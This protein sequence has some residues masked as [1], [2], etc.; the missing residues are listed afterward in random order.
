MKNLRFHAKRLA[1]SLDRNQ[2]IQISTKN[3][4]FIEFFVVRSWF[5]RNQTTQKVNSLLY[6]PKGVLDWQLRRHG[7]VAGEEGCTNRGSDFDD[8]AGVHLKTPPRFADFL[9]HILDHV[10]SNRKPIVGIGSRHPHPHDKRW[11]GVIFKRKMN[12]FGGANRV[13]PLL[14]PTRQP[15]FQHLQGAGVLLFCPSFVFALVTTLHLPI[16]Q[17]LDG[18]FGVPIHIDV[19]AIGQPHAKHLGRGVGLHAFDLDG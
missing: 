18:E 4:E 13:K 2:K 12:R 17:S 3:Q 9:L 8:I 15:F 1:N 5:G 7:W 10:R 11:H 16:K 6:R 14:V 19:H